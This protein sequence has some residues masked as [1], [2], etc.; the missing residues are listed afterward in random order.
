[1]IKAILAVGEN[2]EIGQNGNM[3][4]GRCL[5]KDLECFKKQTIDNIVVMGNT[6]YKSLGKVKGLKA[7]DNRVLSSC[8]SPMNKLGYKILVDEDDHFLSYHNFEHLR[9]CVEFNF[10]D[11]YI[12][13]IGGASIY[14]QFWDYV[15]EVHITR[16]KAS[17]PNADTFFQP[18]LVGF[19]KVGEEVDVSGED[20]EAYV[21]VWRR[22]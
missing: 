10:M 8:I 15:T 13:L 14:E 18:D 5:P 6:T 11:K 3:P 19:E 16:V 20:L 4:W 9:A 7:R 22:V 21:E 1:M 12:W 17:F 2:G